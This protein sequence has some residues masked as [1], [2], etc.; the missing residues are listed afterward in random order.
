[1]AMVS[2]VCRQPGLWIMAGWLMAQADRLG[3]EV[4]SHL[5]LCCFHRMNRVNY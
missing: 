1:M 4:G 2:V 3:P 5:V